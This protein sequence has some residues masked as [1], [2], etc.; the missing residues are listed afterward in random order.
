[1]VG[2]FQHI[3]KEDQGTYIPGYAPDAFKRSWT[4]VSAVIWDGMGAIKIRIGADIHAA[5]SLTSLLWIAAEE[6]MTL[7]RLMATR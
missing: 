6:M 4:P 3:M 5:L 2:G 7:M 1:M